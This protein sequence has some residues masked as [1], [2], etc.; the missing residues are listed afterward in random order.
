M[1]QCPAELLGRLEA[2]AHRRA[3][4]AIGARDLVA[5]KEAVGAERRH[6][7]RQSA[8]RVGLVHDAGG[9]NALRHCR[10]PFML[11]PASVAE[12]RPSVEGSSSDLQSPKRRNTMPAGRVS[13]SSGTRKGMNPMKTF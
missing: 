7:G 12:A 1:D 8:E 4:A 2:A 13:G 11:T 10:F 6:V 9:E 3:R 5:E